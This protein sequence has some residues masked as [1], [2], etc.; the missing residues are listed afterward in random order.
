MKNLKKV[1]ILSLSTALSLG[2]LAPVA[3]ASSFGNEQPNQLQVLVASKESTVTKNDLIKKFKS[4]FPKQFDFLTD[5]DFHMNTGHRYPEDDT[6]RYDLNFHK[7]VDGKNVYGYIGFVGKD[8]EIESFHYEPAN[9]ADALFPA[10]VTKEEAKKIATDFMKRFP[11]GAEYVIEDNSY[12]PYRN[13]T[14]TEPIRYSFSFVSTK[15]KVLIPDQ[16]VE[17]TILGNGEVVNFYRNSKDL[18]SFTFDDTG[19]MKS[20]DAVTKQVKAN[21]SVDLQYQLDFDYQTGERNV[22][23]VYKPTGQYSGVHALSGEW[24]TANGFAKDL[25][26][27]KKLEMLSATPLAPKQSNFNVDKAKELAEQLLAVESDKVKLRIE[28]VEERENHFGK[29]VISINYMYEYQNGGHGTNLELDKDTGEIIQYYNIQRELLTQIGE[30]PNKGKELSREQALNKALEYLKEYAPSYVHNYAKPTEEYIVDDRENYHFSFPR[31]VDGIV[32]SGDQINM[33]VS[34]DGTLMNLNVGYQDVEAWP[35]SDKVISAYDARTLYR[36]ALSLKLNYVMQPNSKENHYHLVYSPLF[37]D[38]AYNLLDANTGEWTNL[39]DENTPPVVTHPWAEEE[40]NYLIDAKILKVEDVDSFDANASV[41][42]G[43][44]LEVILKSLTYFHEG[45]P[46]DREET[47]QTFENIDPKHPLYQV[48][49]RAVSLG[50]L[51][52]NKSK[53]DFDK[54]LTREELAVWYIRALGLEQ[55]AKHSNIYKLDF[56][57]ANKVNKEYYGYVALANSME[58]LTTEKNQFN[59]DQD[60]NYAQLAVSTLRLAHKVYENGGRLNYY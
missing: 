23:L 29:K 13:Q 24:Q 39:M 35:S 36:K 28:S 20:E 60:V 7:T 11:N 22:R 54:N 51:D 50:V 8:L 27:I 47:K 57:D 25:P 34:T 30:A 31:V 4:F 41:T 59:P 32:V 33:M 18:K 14:L 52:D 45:Y 53:F 9:T 40:L 43:E 56:A 58:L 17:I 38:K 46:P 48:V 42:K 16:R 55:A 44:A 5:N 2:I 21:F 19:K 10:K 12:Y 37:N 1:G 15:D 6:I 3:S 49:E 26:E